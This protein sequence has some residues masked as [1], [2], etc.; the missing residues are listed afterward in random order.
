MELQIAED[1]FRKEN[2]NLLSQNQLKHFPVKEVFCRKG[3]S[4]AVWFTGKIE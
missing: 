4:E 1:S 2:I 3:L